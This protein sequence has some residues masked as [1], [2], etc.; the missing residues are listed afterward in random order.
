VDTT[1]VQRAN[2]AEARSAIERNA[3]SYRTSLKVWFG[4]EFGW[5]SILD[6]YTGEV[7]DVELAASPRWFLWR[8]FDEKRRRMNAVP[9]SGAVPLQNGSRW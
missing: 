6:P 2:A 5:C 3:R 8:C 7:Y 9:R 4:G 1:A